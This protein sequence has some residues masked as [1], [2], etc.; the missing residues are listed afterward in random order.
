M[1]MIVVMMV[2]VVMVVIVVMLVV[3]VMLH[4]LHG[5]GKGVDTLHNV[6]YLLAVKLRPGSG[7]DGRVGVELAEHSGR[8]D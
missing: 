8:G 1:L 4:L 6:N 7:D 3:I 5:G 2:L